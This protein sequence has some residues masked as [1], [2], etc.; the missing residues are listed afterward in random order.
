MTLKDDLYL[1]QERPS[2]RHSCLVRTILAG[3]PDIDRAAL[4][5]ILDDLTI[6][7]AQISRTLIANNIIAKAG[8]VSKHRNRD[9]SCDVLDR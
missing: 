1:L 3:L 6:S 4:Q 7:S 2:L 9:C 5:T 8:V